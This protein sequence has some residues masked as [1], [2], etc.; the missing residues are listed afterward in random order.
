M[1]EYGI[2]FKR[3]RKSKNMSQS[4]VAYGILSAAALSKFENEKST[5]SADKFVQLLDRIRMS[6]EEFSFIYL[7][8]LE[9][10]QS[11]F[12]LNLNQARQDENIIQIQQLINKELSL[13]QLNNNIIHKHNIT[14]C[15]QVINN[16]L[17]KPY[18][19]V[20]VDKIYDFLFSIVN[21]GY[22]EVSLF[23]NMIFCFNI[24]QIRHLSKEATKK[25]LLYKRLSKNRFDLVILLQ[26]IVSRLIK[27]QILESAKDLL[28]E[29]DELLRNTQ[30][31]YEMNRQK[32]LYGLYYIMFGDVEAGKKKC[33]EAIHI[34]S[35]FNLYSK[36]I[37]LQKEME[38]AI[39]SIE[40]K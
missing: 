31:L 10:S 15:N 38:A 35:E 5:I 24:N 13:F 17:S 25:T 40:A 7:D 28:G 33:M 9:N 30:Y 23:A 26:N 4:E 19:M 12:L 39:A 1:T 2:A 16:I 6:F 8:D 37:S 34:F 29:V 18:D 11:S 14:H 27:E 36:A 21:W 32:Y 22:Y 3:A 20:E